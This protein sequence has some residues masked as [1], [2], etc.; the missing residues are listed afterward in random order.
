[1]HRADRQ[2][3]HDAADRAGAAIGAEDEAGDCAAKHHGQ[4]QGGPGRIESHGQVWAI[5]EHGDEMGGPDPTAADC[6][7]A[8][9]PALLTIATQPPR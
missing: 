8:D 6:A 1:V 9:Q 3:D 7:G 2:A 5:A 4:R